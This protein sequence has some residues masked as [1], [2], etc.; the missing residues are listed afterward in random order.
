M[1]DP[2]VPGGLGQRGGATFPGEVLP[3][4]RLGECDAFD[5][6]RSHVEV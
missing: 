6:G 3:L 1:A 5:Y 4:Q 2:S